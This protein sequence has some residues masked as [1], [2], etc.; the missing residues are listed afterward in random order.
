M[1]KAKR[2]GALL[3]CGAIVCSMASAGFPQVSAGGTDITVTFTLRG[4]EKHGTDTPHT[5]YQN[6]VWDESYTLPAGS[7]VYDLIERAAEENGLST[8]WTESDYGGEYLSACGGL[9]ESD[10]AMYSGW[11]FAVNGQG[12]SVSMSLYEL[13]DGENVLVYYCDDYYSLMGSA[14]DPAV[15]YVRQSIAGIGAVTTDSRR[16]IEETREAYDNLGPMQDYLTAEEKKTLTDAES[17]LSSLYGDEAADLQA[18]EQVDRRIGSIGTVTAHSG[19]VIEEVRALYDALTENQKKY[20]D[21]LAVLEAAEETLLFLQEQGQENFD[22]IFRETGDALLSQEEK[23]DWVLLGLAR[24]G[25][26]P[27]NGGQAYLTAL[28]KAESEKLSATKAT[29]NARAVLTLTALGIDPRDV[30]GKDFTRPLTDLSY[31]QR[32]GINGPIW[33]LIALSSHEYGDEAAKMALIDSILTAQLADGG[34]ALS[35]D[36]SEADVTA[37]ALTALAPYRDT[38][39]AV[40]AAVEKGVSLL[41]AMQVG[42]E[43]PTWSGY[44]GFADRDGTVNAESCAQVVTALCSL[45]IDPDA[46]ERFIKGDGYGGQYSALDAL[47]AFYT[48]GGFAHTAYGQTDGL[49]TEQAYYA[50]TAVVRLKNGQAPLFTMTE[51]GFAG[52]EPGEPS[53]PAAGDGTDV[54]AILGMTVLCG[55]LCVLM[56]RKARRA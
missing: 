55:A 35:G 48:G 52:K 39:K 44:G 34:W 6:W 53:T 42:P 28:R 13:S 54:G 30:D 1:R 12:P 47:L 22:T 27:E 45:G 21:R 25:K 38:D 3:L 15:I 29:E 56:H 50:M 7:T 16:R 31:V 49:A 36:R 17:T 40:Q 18:A 33:A 46:D 8:Q 51:I 37:M 14:D 5:A 23:S 26:L 24:A 11:M 4:D 43:S 9:A 19:P 41:S 20:V 32:Q 2:A 10:N